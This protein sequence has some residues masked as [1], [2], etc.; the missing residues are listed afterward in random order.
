MGSSHL[1]LLD[2][3]SQNPIY[4]STRRMGTHPRTEL[5]R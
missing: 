5:I 2:L 1:I 4:E 3:S